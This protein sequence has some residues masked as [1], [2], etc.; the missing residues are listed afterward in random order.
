MGGFSVEEM[1]KS[2]NIIGK[3]GF[4]P[5]LG[6]F[7][8]TGP[9]AVE[10]FTALFG[11]KT[12]EVIHRLLWIFVGKFTFPQACGEL[13]PSVHRCP[14]PRNVVKRGFFVEKQGFLVFYTNPKTR[15]CA[16]LTFSTRF[17]TTCGKVMEKSTG[18]LRKRWKSRGR[19]ELFPQAGRTSDG[20][21]PL[22]S[23][24]ISSISVRK[25]GF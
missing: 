1:C 19:I 14:Q 24:T 8:L 23:L 4:C 6:V 10:K 2:P 17:S 15:T 3:E 13:I 20:Q 21:L 22:I 16:K 18:R 7:R 12:G 9:V 11:G 5:S 25:T